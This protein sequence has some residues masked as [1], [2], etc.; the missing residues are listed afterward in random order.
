[1]LKISILI[2]AFSEGIR[3]IVGVPVVH[4]GNAIILVVFCLLLAKGNAKGLKM[5]EVNIILL[6]G[7][8]FLLFTSIIGLIYGVRPILFLWSL[9]R[10]LIFYCLFA[11][12][13]MIFGKEDIP[14]FYRMLDGVIVIH[15]VLTLV[16]FFFFG[17]SWDYLNGI[18]G[19]KMGG[20]A[21]V[22]I[23][24][25]VNTCV[26]FYRFYKREM[27][28]WLLLVH[29]AWMCYN[30]ALN[31]LKLYVVELVAAMVIYVVVTKEVKRELKLLL[32]VMII[33]FTSTMLMIKLYPWCNSYYGKL[34]FDTDTVISVPHHDNPDSLGR[35][36]Q[37]YGL[38]EPIVDYAV[39]HRP[40]LSVLSPVT[41]L[42][43]GNAELST[44]GMFDSE[45]YH[46]NIRLWY[47]DFLLSMVYVEGGIIGLIF[48]NMA[49]IVVLVRSFSQ[50]VKNGVDEGLIHS[51]ACVMV[52]F[53]IVYD[54]SMRNNYGYMMWVF[55]GVMYGCMRDLPEKEK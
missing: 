42:G 18:F 17:I 21:G 55:L 54:A 39:K 14:L 31:E 35:K 7:A 4:A 45:F 37:I 50:S 24:L 8:A 43:L 27:K 13:F 3:Q 47:W 49:W 32:P 36:N 23:L 44:N 38:T 33:I 53:A 19:T 30:A 41:G 15:I 25:A 22:N 28:W 29:I 34:L 16:Q 26:C 40:M 52:L 46:T 11:D 20:N 51:F 5:P 1:M 2:C 48:Y 12:C 6:G 10:Y 9:R